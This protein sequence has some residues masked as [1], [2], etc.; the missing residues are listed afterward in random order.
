MYKIN[1][2]FIARKK[3][4]WHPKQIVG[5]ISCNLLRK[6]ENVFYWLVASS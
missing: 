4:K 5:D 1:K 6:P 2:F 3:Q